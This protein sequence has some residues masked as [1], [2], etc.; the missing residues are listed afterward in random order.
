[1]VLDD[2]LQAIQQRGAFHQ[3]HAMV[4]MRSG[5]ALP[6][7]S[8]ASIEPQHLPVG[9]DNLALPSGL[10]QCTAQGDQCAMPSIPFHGFAYRAS[11]Q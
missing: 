11:L 5:Q 3:K 7:E 9:L 8:P 10:F 4:I 1:M 6:V 2:R